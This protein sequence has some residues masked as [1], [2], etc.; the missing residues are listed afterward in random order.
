MGKLVQTRLSVEINRSRTGLHSCILSL[1]GKVAD[2]LM[3]SN[4][5]AFLHKPVFLCMSRNTHAIYCH[6]C[7]FK[8][9]LSKDL[10]CFCDDILFINRIDFTFACRTFSSSLDSFK[11]TVCF[12]P[13]VLLYINLLVC[14]LVSHPSCPITS[15]SLLGNQ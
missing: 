6:C 5:V 1:A 8:K 4:G 9:K 12:C 7:I 10:P 15:A 14:S 2:R 13:S 11:P 3:A